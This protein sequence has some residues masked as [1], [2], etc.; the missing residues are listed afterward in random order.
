VVQ[1]AVVPRSTSPDERALAAFG[2]II[3]GL[4]A[5][6]SWTR[7]EVCGWSG[8]R[9]AYSTLAGVENGHRAPGER[10]LQALAAGLGVPAGELG[11]LWQLVRDGAGSEEL[12]PAVDGLRTA[13]DRSDRQRRSDPGERLADVSQQLASA[14]ATISALARSTTP[15]VLQ[16]ASILGPMPGLMGA[17][18]AGP[19]T[20]PMSEP[21][22]DPARG[23]RKAARP[24]TS[25]AGM[26][27]RMV[28]E[29]AE[30]AGELP[31]QDLAALLRITRSLRERVG[32]S[33]SQHGRKRPE[34]SSWE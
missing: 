12:D 24:A 27:A 13:V 10:S 1:D 30:L 11:A 15:A 4:R 29:L 23:Y 3:E 2:S 18:T 6:R 34:G 25:A 19:M 21:M 9:L 5:R 31:E 16:S 33:D 20:E 32:S 14:Q 17:L 7:A 22:S 8:G 26:R 28:A